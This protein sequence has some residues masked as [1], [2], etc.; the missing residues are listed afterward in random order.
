MGIDA[1]EIL[2]ASGVDR[3]EAAMIA[4]DLKALALELKARSR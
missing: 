4:A 1:Q 3:A 2:V